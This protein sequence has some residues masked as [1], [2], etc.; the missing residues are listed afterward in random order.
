VAERT[1]TQPRGDARAVADASLRAIVAAGHPY[2]ARVAAYHMGWA[3]ADG[4]PTTA[5]SGKGVRPALALLS[6]RLAGAEAEVGVPGAVA[7]ELV[8]NFSLLHDDVLDEDVL[9]RGRPTAWTVFGVGAA[10]LAGDALLNAAIEVVSAHHAATRRMV[11]AVDGLIVGQC[12][13]LAFET[14]DDVSIVEYLEMAA[15]KTGALFGCAASVGAVLADAPAHVVDALETFGRCLGIAFQA[16]DDLL[17]IWGSP[18]VTAK[19]NRSDLRRGKKTLPV[20]AALRS[21]HPAV[22]ELAALLRRRDLGDADLDRAAELV[23]LTGGRSFTSTV[24]DRRLAEAIT[25]LDDIDPDPA[26]RAETVALATTLVNRD[27]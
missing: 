21:T 23:E 7:V 22:P 26:V 9:R 3:D 4:T 12:R 2:S 16:V 25:A 1:T 18:S 17:G 5:N 11:D 20:L 13:D 6:A 19:S 8:H 27:R 10:V 15:G 14:R 24:A